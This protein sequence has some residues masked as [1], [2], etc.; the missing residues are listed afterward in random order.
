MAK[1]YFTKL[2]MYRGREFLFRAAHISH[3]H[4]LRPLSLAHYIQKDAGR[5]VVLRPDETISALSQL[6]YMDLVQNHYTGLPLIFPESVHIELGA[7]TVSPLSAP[8]PVTRDDM[9]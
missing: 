3:R 1:Y 4:E 8:F 7:I 6:L 9:N 2:D 5:T